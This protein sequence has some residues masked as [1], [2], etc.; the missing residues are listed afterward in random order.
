MKKLL[1][2]LTLMFL[3]VAY[4]T[5][6]Q[7]DPSSSKSLNLP[8]SSPLPADAHPAW[9]FT[10]L[11]TIGSYG[12]STIAVSD[13]DQT[14]M[15]NVY[16]CSATNRMANSA[17][18]STNGGSISFIEHPQI[19][20]AWGSYIIKAVD[21]SVSGGVASGSNVQTI[22]SRATS[23][24][25]Q[26]TAQAW[27]P[28]SGVNKIA[29]IGH[30]PAEDDIYTISTSGGTPTKIYSIAKTDGNFRKFITW[31]N[32]GTKLAFAVDTGTST[33][34]KD[35]IKIIDLSGNVQATLIPDKYVAIFGVQW[36]HSGTD[37]IAFHATTSTSG[38][39]T[40]YDIYTIGTTT[41]STE[42]KVISANSSMA[43]WSP[44]NSE[45]VYDISA[46][47]INSGVNKINVSSG[48]NTFVGTSHK[49][50]D[51]KTP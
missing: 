1:F 41:G 42:T 14:D 13:S 33:N 4:L 18:W 28:A 9:A 21:V 45:L 8:M 24:S 51:W 17:T 7:Q 43:F 31:G 38:A 22:Y 16:T 23:D 3:T 27:C 49:F 12:Y 32:D 44:N 30:T 2:T 46:A 47:G 39:S 34:Y 5:G 36:S 50:G 10:G 6:C 25:M 35:A 15:A 40:S 48:A 29:F 19:A 20:S 26:I 11:K 37:Q